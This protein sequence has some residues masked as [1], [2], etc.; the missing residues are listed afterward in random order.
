MVQ[1]IQQKEVRTIANRVYT[2][3]EIVLNNEERDIP[4]TLRPLPIARLREFMVQWGKME[5]MNEKHRKKKTEPT[6]DEVFGV[7][8]RCCGVA[9]RKQLA[10]EVDDEVFDDKREFTQRYIDLLEDFLELDSIVKILDICG[11]VRL[12]DPK[13][14]AAMEEMLEE[15]ETAP[16][17]GTD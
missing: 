17:V 13:L 14:M 15:Q 11:G 7:Y 10:S 8:V 5:E 2:Q 16:E 9:L 3:E 4:V 12:T 1:L 6:E